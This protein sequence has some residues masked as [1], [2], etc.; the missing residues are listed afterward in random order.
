MEYT[1]ES[2]KMDL[3]TVGFSET[4]ELLGQVENELRR[5]M[6]FR[7]DIVATDI[8]LREEGG[9]D[10]A[11]N[12]VARWRLGV[13]GNDLFAEGTGS[14]WAASLRDAGDKLRRQFVD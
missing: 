14:S 6:R 8:Y 7:S 2:I 3:Q 1:V 10:P 11:N 9:S 13:P 4:P 5:V 12:Y